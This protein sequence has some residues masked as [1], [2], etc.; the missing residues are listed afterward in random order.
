[1]LLQGLRFL[2]H[3][4]D[5]PE[6]V[7]TTLR[8]AIEA[9]LVALIFGLPGACAI[10]LGR[11]RVSRWGLVLANTG[12]GLP[13]VAVGVYFFLLVPPGATAP[14]GGTWIDTLNGMVAVQTV[15][16]LPIIVAVTAIA[17]RS[18]PDGLIDQSRAFGASGWRLGLFSLREARLGLISAVIFA[19]GSAF[20]EVGAVSLISGVGAN[21]TTL[22]TRV[23]LDVDGYPGLAGAIAHLIV[24]LA[25]MFALGLVL[26]CVQ[27]YDS[28]RR[29]VLPR[30]LAPVTT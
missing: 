7:V 17:I 20:G 3:D 8:L 24:L 9:T 11:A 15:L 26:A 29:R 27:R 25:M 10:G 13:P 28:R 14:W 18:L 22:A 1:M 16:A 23:L 12:L 4:P 2:P 19:I 6:Q 5:L 30:T 21:Q